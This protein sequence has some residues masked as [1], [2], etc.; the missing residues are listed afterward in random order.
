M[1][2][3]IGELDNV[4]GLNR[5]SPHVLSPPCQ[6]GGFL[7]LSGQGTEQKVDAGETMALKDG[8]VHQL[9]ISGNGSIRLLAMLG[10][11]RPAS[12]YTL[13]GDAGS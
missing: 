6:L 2:P 12:T 4:R 13:D 9:G 8:D 1:T 11:M 5:V 10:E 7:I 3:E